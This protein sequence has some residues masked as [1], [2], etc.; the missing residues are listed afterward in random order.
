MSEKI[1]LKKDVEEKLSR[2]AG[3]EVKIVSSLKKRKPSGPRVSF[4]VTQQA[5]GSIQQ[6]LKELSKKM[7]IEP[8]ELALKALLIGLKD[9]TTKSNDQQ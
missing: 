5:Q 7:G 6:A 4:A 1:L 3:K 9:L 8:E 2:R